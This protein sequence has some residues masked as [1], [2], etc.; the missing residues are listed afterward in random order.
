MLVSL[1]TAKENL[2]V[3]Y[4]SLASF[5]DN[6]EQLPQ[7]IMKFLK[8]QLLTWLFSSCCSWPVTPLDSINT[9]VLKAIW[10]L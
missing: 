7:G 5:S 8:S 4:L 3:N 6:F 9:V 1:P 2:V 10:D